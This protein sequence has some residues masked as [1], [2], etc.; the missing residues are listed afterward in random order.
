VVVRQ[1][2]W[3]LLPEKMARTICEASCIALFFTFKL[4]IVVESPSSVK[5]E[6]KNISFNNTVPLVVFCLDVI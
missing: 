5:S 3:T 6:Y 4:K 2:R 1:K